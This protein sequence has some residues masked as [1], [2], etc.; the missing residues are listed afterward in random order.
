MRKKIK[1]ISILG[2]IDIE[3]GFFDPVGSKRWL[4]L[5]NLSTIP[6]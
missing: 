4:F 6:R 1:F 3:K 5:L 2:H